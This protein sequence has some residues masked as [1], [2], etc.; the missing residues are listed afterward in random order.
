MNYQNSYLSD[1]N[2]N[3]KFIILDELIELIYTNDRYIIQN[4]TIIKDIKD[5]N[6]KQKV[7]LLMFINKYININPLISIYNKYSFLLFKKIP[8]LVLDTI[9]RGVYVYSDLFKKKRK[10]ANYFW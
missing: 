7:I 3:Y 2:F 10:R 6:D 9:F 5:Y 8:P 4:N 1:T